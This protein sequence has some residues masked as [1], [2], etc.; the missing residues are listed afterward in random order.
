MTLGKSLWDRAAG[1]EGAQF[2]QGKMGQ[3]G[4]MGSD[5]WR[6]G[7]PLPLTAGLRVPGRLHFPPSRRGPPVSPDNLRVGTNW[8]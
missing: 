5:G 2:L 3:P 8:D 4:Q 1:G 6:E 7:A